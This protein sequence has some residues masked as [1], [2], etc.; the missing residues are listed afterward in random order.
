MTFWYGSQC[1]SGMPKSYGSY[2]SGS[3]TLVKSP[4]QKKSRFFFTIFAWWW[5]DPDPELDPEQGPYLWLTDPDADPGGQKTYTDPDHPVRI[6]NTEGNWQIKRL[7]SLLWAAA[8]SCINIKISLRKKLLC[9]YKFSTQHIPHRFLQVPCMHM[10]FESGGGGGGGGRG[11]RFILVWTFQRMHTE[12]YTSSDL[13]KLAS[14][15]HDPTQ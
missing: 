10:W 4:K 14:W 9:M 15:T 3:G 6:P 7:Y 8:R 12:L 13:V 1:G 2:G 11:Q 5:K